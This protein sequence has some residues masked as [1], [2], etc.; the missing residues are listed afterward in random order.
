MTQCAWCEVVGPVRSAVDP[1]CRE[2][3]GKADNFD[4]DAVTQAGFCDR[5]AA[6]HWNGK[7]VERVVGSLTTHPDQFGN[8]YWFPILMTWGRLA[9][10]WP[11]TFVNNVNESEAA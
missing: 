4:V 10:G 7:A 11:G 5:V 8:V 2:C 6:V 1:V 9:V 3:N